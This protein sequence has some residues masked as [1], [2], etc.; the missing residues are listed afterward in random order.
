MM[1]GGIIISQSIIEYLLSLKN[2]MMLF[3]AVEIIV[4]PL[5]YLGSVVMMLS[6]AVE[7]TM[8]ALSYLGSVVLL[9]KKS[10]SELRDLW[11]NR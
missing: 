10:V 4:F 5:F 8:G 1:V 7:I 2:V 9:D 3:L 6:L 11:K